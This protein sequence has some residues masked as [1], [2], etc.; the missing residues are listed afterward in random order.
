MKNIKPI[1]NNSLIEKIFFNE[2]WTFE[3]FNATL[4]RYFKNK[5]VDG[6]AQGM[7]YVPTVPWT[8]LVVNRLVGS[9]EM[10]LLPF[11]KSLDKTP[12]NIIF[13][14]GA[15]EGFYA[16]GSLIRWSTTTVYA[17]EMD[18]RARSI[19][20]T[21][22][23]KNNVTE[24]INIHEICTQPILQQAIQSL[25]P[26]LIIMDVEGEELNLCTEMI[27]MA[28]KLAKWVIE[29]HSPDIVT[30]LQNRFKNTHHIEIINNWE[31]IIP[32]EEIVIPEV[33][34]LTLLRCV[35]KNLFSIL[36]HYP[37]KSNAL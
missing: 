8:R 2:I 30:T 29:C 7:E 15:A 4:C 11:F 17:W 37:C 32:V 33:I 3:R 12:P 18:T 1:N 22:A 23:T 36:Y 25:N 26:E 9:Y 6:F 27:I 5:I 14:I 34:K 31:K 24:R 10:E 13:D 28:G 19:M 21:L 16:V 20:Q 35:I